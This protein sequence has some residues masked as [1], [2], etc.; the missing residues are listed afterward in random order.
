MAYG[1]I[2]F[3]TNFIEPLRNILSKINIRVKT[4]QYIPLI[5]NPIVDNSNLAIHPLEFFHK[6]FS[7]D[8]SSTQIQQDK[9]ITR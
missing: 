5:L 6:F 4:N 7:S 8:N 2:Y 9:S 3:F 1:S